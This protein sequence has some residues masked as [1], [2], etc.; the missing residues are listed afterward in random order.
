MVIYSFL[1]STNS[2]LKTCSKFKLI[3]QQSHNPNRDHPQHHH[4]QPLARGRCGRP[5][6]VV[7][8]KFAPTVTR[9]QWAARPA[10]SGLRNFGSG[11]VLATGR[12]HA[13]TRSPR[14]RLR[15]GEGDSEQR[16]SQPSLAARA[17]WGSS[18]YICMSAD[19]NR[20]F[21]GGELEGEIQTLPPRL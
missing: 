9:S 12:M 16:G 4:Q 5:L 20:P 7:S 10:G 11:R 13:S 8:L 19:Q 1:E 18:S 14:A 17:V 21:P 15:V 6:L 2:N 3:D